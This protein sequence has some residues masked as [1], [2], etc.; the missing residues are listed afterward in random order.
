MWGMDEGRQAKATFN[1][2]SYKNRYEGLREEFGSDLRAYYMHYINYGER[3]G[4]IAT[5]YENTTDTD[6]ET[7]EDKT[8]VTIYN[9]VDYSAVYDYSYYIAHNQGVYEEYGCV[10]YT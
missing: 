9:G 10:K 4:R 2:Y 7:E 6:T 5:G 3:E 1:V 8:Y